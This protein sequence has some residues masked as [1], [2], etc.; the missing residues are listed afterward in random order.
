MREVLRK[1]SGSFGG[2]M[3]NSLLRWLVP[4]LVVVGGG[5]AVALAA[6]DGPMTDD[7]VARGSTVLAHDS[8]WARFEINGRDAVLSGTAASQAQIDTAVAELSAVPGIASVAVAAQITKPVS[9]Y[10]F[11]ATLANGALSLAGGYPSEAVHQALLA[12]AGAA[13]DSMTLLAGAPDSAA[14]SAAAEFGLEALKQMD[15]GSIA[16]SDLS[17]SVEGRARSAA[18]YDQL[19][20]LGARL[21]SGVTLAEA[22]ITPPVAAPYI[23]TA[24]YDGT[25]LR[26]E[27]GEPDAGFKDRLRA[28]IPATIPV[29]LALTPASGEPA[30]FDNNALALLQSLLSLDSGTASIKG[31]TIELSGTPATGA[32]ADQVTAAV[33]ALGGTTVLDA[34]QSGDFE[35]MI[36]KAASGISFSGTVPDKATRQ[37]LAAIDGADVAK[38]EIGRGAPPHFADA[39]QFGRDAAGYLQAGQVDIRRSKLSVSGTAASGADFKSL[40]TLLAEAPQGYSVSSSELHPPAATPFTWTAT[41]AADG[42]IS[43]TGYAPD[44][45]ARTAID[46]KLSSSSNDLT[47]IADGA[48]DGFVQSAGQGLGVLVLLD[49]GKVSFDGTHWSIEG[50]VDSVKKAFTADAAYSVAGLRTAGWNYVLHKPELPTISPY[51]WRAQKV[52]AGVVEISGYSPDDAFQQAVKAH[53]EHVTD[54]TTLGAGAPAGFNTAAIAAL[55]ALGSLNEGSLS[56]DGSTW[57]LSGTVADSATR[58]AVQAKLNAATNTAGWSISIT[59]KDTAPVVAPYLWSATKTADGGIA[60]SGYVPSDTV[61]TDATRR[62]AKVSGDTTAIASGEPAGFAENVTAGLDALGHLTSGRAMFDGNRWSLTGNVATQADGEAAVAAISGASPAGG[63]WNVTLTGYTPPASSSSMASSSVAPVV[64]SSS[65]EA[66]PASDI[67]SIAPLE[68]PSSSSS[69]SAEA[70]TASSSTDPIAASSSEASASSSEVAAPSSAPPASSASSSSVPSSAEQAMSSSSEAAPSSSSIAPPSEEP[71]QPEAALPP[72]PDTLAFEAALEPGGSVALKGSAPAAADI[73]AI[74]KATGVS[75]KNLK[76]AAGLP[77]GFTASATG[78]VAVLSK[79]GQGRLGFDGTRWWLRA[80]AYT[81]AARDSAITAIAAIPGSVDWSVGISVLAPM[82]ACRTRI[83]AIAKANSIQFTGRATLTKSSIAVIDDLAAALQACASSAVHVQAH[84]DS[85][86]GAQANLGVSVAR[87]EA[88]I[89]E[90]VKQ[91]VDE[92]RLYA[93]GFGESDP[94]ATND[95]KAGKAANRRVTFE[96][97]PP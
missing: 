88:V 66:P 61:K 1:F 46:A 15:Q 2:G 91:G 20:G 62:A 32:V 97:D 74:G 78:G 58:D 14:F 84:T 47:E 9:P 45:A 16:L 87:A 26:I 71:S 38:L 17:L 49:S 81:A 30:A 69:S 56:L 18:D 48:P 19:L 3:A 52:A 60:F 64:S 37:K 72:I 6:T 13:A 41:K 7:L 94:V 89:A 76:A 42:T 11:S 59:A 55:D 73:K 25:G 51:I 44:E 63:T 67:T 29:D 95:T 4:G 75:T 27:G 68:P 86:G 24:I 31:S 22:A 83:A 65:S 40:T 54:N 33:A 39:L 10:P 34:P 12:D 28:A 43:I 36:T 82:D 85:D 57:S 23:W 92:G 77:A 8:S 80:T 70:S 50:T 5:T 21:P 79:L 35:L 53:A 93:E 96:L 90:L